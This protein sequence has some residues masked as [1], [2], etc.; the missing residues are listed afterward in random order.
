M[1]VV[2][3]VVYL[4][5]VLVVSVRSMAVKMCM[6]QDF[7]RTFRPPLRTCSNVGKKTRYVFC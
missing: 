7:L 2:N 1:R 5:N 3:C 4:V 6:G